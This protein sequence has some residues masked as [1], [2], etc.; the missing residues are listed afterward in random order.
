MDETVTQS[1]YN[2]VGQ[3]EIYI[4]LAPMHTLLSLCN[5]AGAMHKEP[6]AREQFGNPFVPLSLK[7]ENPIPNIINYYGIYGGAF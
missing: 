7:G 3:G 5:A 4:E 6:Q 2:S 1:C